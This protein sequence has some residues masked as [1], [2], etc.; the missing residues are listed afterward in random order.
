MAVRRAH[1]AHGLRG[2]VAV[3]NA[4]TPRE[5]VTVETIEARW[6]RQ[7]ERLYLVAEK[8]GRAVG[9]AMAAP[10]D[11][12]GRLFLDVRVLFEER[13]QGVGSA[14]Y[15]QLEAHALA[16]APKA[17]STQVS[18][19][20]S[21]GL[22]FA[23]QRGY[24]EVDR[25]VELVRTLQGDE[26]PP[27]RLAGVEIV[28]L[29]EEMRPAAYVVTRQAWADFPLSAAVPPPDWDDWVRD[30]FDGPIAFAAL[31]KGQV[32]GF[33]ALTRRPA[34]GLLEHGLTACLRA[35]RGRGIGTALKQ[36]Q[37]AWAA[38]HGYRELI[39]F[40]Q[41]GNEAMRSVNAKLGYVEQPAW[42][43]MRRDLA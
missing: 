33:A 5:P 11:S 22:R 2:V 29:T 9:T 14:L 28:E 30:E 39:T 21:G 15:E 43:T 20:S 18:E 17:L 40:T 12:P 19:V 3:W 34:D 4:I 16:L 27:P 42:L 31:E 24:R 25:Q 38:A 8:A 23:R 10:S 37:I 41:D 35:H 26:R 32:V 13:R 6:A 7:P 36:A 1:D